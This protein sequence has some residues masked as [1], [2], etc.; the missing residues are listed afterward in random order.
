LPILQERIK[1]IV[2]ERGRLMALL[3]TLP[4]V[5]MTPSRANFVLCRL[6]NVDAKETHARLMAQGIM[7]R[8]FDTPL[9]R[10]HLRI[11]IGLPEQNDAVFQALRGIIFA[12]SQPATG[13]PR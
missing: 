12:M 3:S 4:G 9:L 8:Y 5:E 10:N 11:T 6:N 1:A 13:A 7:V 2:A